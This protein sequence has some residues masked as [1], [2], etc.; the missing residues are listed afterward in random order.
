MRIEIKSKRVFDIL[1]CLIFTGMWRIVWWAT[2]MFRIASLKKKWWGK[3]K[4][5]LHR[6]T[7]KQII[8][9][10]NSYINVCMRA[11]CQSRSLR[12]YLC[13]AAVSI[14]M[15]FFCKKQNKTWNM[16]TCSKGVDDSWMS[17]GRWLS[18]V[19]NTVWLIDVLDKFITALLS[20]CQ[21]S[22]FQSL[23]SVSHLNSFIMS[24]T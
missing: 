21:Y 9:I 15:I 16:W 8:W 3:K 13:W 4:S 6:Y 5:L 12:S 10:R 7:W 19:W 24:I 2:L 17:C 18:C 23:T 1:H 11:K 14:L 22:L 20:P